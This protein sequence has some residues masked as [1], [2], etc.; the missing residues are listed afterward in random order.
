MATVC[1][2][3]GTTRF[4]KFGFFI[5]FFLKKIQSHEIEQNPVLFGFITDKLR[6]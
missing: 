1:H 6:L 5:V 4:L 2:K 3:D